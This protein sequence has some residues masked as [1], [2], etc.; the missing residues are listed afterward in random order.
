MESNKSINEIKKQVEK[1]FN[2]IQS[3]MS[4]VER[5]LYELLSDSK[6][7]REMFLFGYSIG[8]LTTM[9]E[10]AMMM[11]GGIDNQAERTFEDKLIKSPFQ[12]KR[13]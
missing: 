13:D 4:N 9:K 8:K 3:E 5:S 1:D 6:M 11:K 2:R 10:V 7:P 12:I